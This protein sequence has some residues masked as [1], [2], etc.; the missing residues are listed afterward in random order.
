M[1]CSFIRSTL[2]L[3]I[4]FTWNE[5]DGGF[6]FGECPH[7]GNML[8]GDLMSLNSLF[9]FFLKDR[10]KVLPFIC[11]VFFF[12]RKKQRR[13]KEPAGSR[14]AGHFLRTNYFRIMFRNKILNQRQTTAN[15]HPPRTLTGSK[16]MKLD[17]L[18]KGKNSREE[19][20]KTKN[21]GI[22]ILTF[23]PSLSCPDSHRQEVI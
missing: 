6:A 21:T 20:K 7:G 8:L 14:H 22:T 4:V 2:S 11:F 16:Q 23:F 15:A 9:I 3:T 12:F 1:F 19:E 13:L 5:A 10:A 17:E 18:P